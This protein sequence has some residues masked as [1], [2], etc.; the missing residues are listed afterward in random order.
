MSQ[1]GTWFVESTGGGGRLASLPTSQ[2]LHRARLAHKASSIAQEVGTCVLFVFWTLP[3]ASPGQGRARVR[4][5]HRRA[6][7]TLLQD[8]APSRGSEPRDVSNTPPP[9]S[10]PTSN[11]RKLSD[12][13]EFSDASGRPSGESCWPM[14]WYGR[15]ARRGC[16][17]TPKSFDLVKIRE[18]SFEIRQNL[19]EPS[20]TPRNLSKNDAKLWKSEQKWRPALIWKQWRPELTWTGFSHGARFDIK[21]FFWRSG[22][23]QAS[24]GEFGKSFF[25]PSKFACSYTYGPMPA[26]I[27]EKSLEDRFSS[28]FYY[29][30][31]S[32]PLRFFPAKHRS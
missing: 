30:C 18:K 21:S 25:A 12:D 22:V 26:S 14:H 17:S 8:R 10:T 6:M 3:W 24:L 28:F 7:M 23:F 20:K 15:R 16:K 31:L 32:R 4:D 29:L 19:W 5:F 27:R 1:V 9:P 11:K 13:E 2:L